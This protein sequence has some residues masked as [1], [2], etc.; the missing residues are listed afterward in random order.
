[1]ISRR[2]WGGKLLPAVR[3]TSTGLPA[4]LNQNL[5]ERGARGGEIALARTEVAAVQSSIGSRSTVT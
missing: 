1:M 4:D 5:D 2:H 3:L